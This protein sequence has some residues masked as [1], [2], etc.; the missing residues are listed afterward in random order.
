MGGVRPSWPSRAKVTSGL[1]VLHGTHPG[2]SPS[3]GACLFPCSLVPGSPENG[4]LHILPPSA[5]RSSIKR[6]PGLP[7]LQKIPSTLAIRR[8][9]SIL[10][11]GERLIQ[12]L[13]SGQLLAF[14]FR[15]LFG[16]KEKHSQREIRKS[17]IPWGP[18]GYQRTG[19]AGL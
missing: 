18:C 3:S 10:H 4:L 1:F 14:G 15:G 2:M 5:L 11:W 13:L 9:T 17:S 16:G 19:T 6:T 12:G 8:Q 7:T